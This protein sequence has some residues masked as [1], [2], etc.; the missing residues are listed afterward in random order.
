MAPSTQFI[1]IWTVGLI[2]LLSATHTGHEESDK[3][4]PRSRRQSGW[5]LLDPLTGRP[6]GSTTGN[7]QT[8]GRPQ[9]QTRQFS[10]QPQQP[11]YKYYKRYPYSG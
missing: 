1:I 4:L 3:I 10:P 8:F 6:L 5:T 2:A 11:S 9:Y 7:R